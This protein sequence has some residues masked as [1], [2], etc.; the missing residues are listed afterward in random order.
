MSKIGNYEHASSLHILKTFVKS[1]PK[2]M[3]KQDV[4]ILISSK[5]YNDVKGFLI[6]DKFNGF[7]V[8]QWT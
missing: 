4:E 6:K 5:I 7:K 1:I 8:K 2:S 3:K